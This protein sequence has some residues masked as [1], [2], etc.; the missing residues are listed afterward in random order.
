MAILTPKKCLQNLKR[1]L[2]FHTMWVL[3]AWFC[4]LVT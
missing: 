2:I 3:L 4:A 1:D